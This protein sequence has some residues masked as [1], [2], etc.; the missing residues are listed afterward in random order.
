MNEIKICIGSSCYARGNDENIETLENYIN[1][2]KED[3]KIELIGLRCTNKCEKGP[4]III[5]GKEYCN[6]SYLEL[7]KILEEL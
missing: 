7:K 5:N 2:H 4:I 6:I 3:S 1:E